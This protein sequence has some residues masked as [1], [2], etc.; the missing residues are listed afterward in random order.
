M[1]SP[2]ACALSYAIGVS[3]NQLISYYV[4]IAR[5]A[6]DEAIS[7]VVGGQISDVEIASPSAR[8][9]KGASVYSDLW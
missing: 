8:N 3:W 1:T 7:L 9:D 6:S 4:V 5:S 2:C